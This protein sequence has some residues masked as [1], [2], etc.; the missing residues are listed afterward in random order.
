MSRTTAVGFAL[1]ALISDPVGGGAPIQ[2]LIGALG[3]WPGAG[4]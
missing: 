3:E 2:R 4:A 1:T